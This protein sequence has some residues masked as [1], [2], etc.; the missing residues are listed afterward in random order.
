MKPPPLFRDRPRAVQVVLGLIAPV[1]FGALC[2]YLLGTSEPWFNGLMVL[3]GLGGIG[4]GYEHLGARDG[5]LRGIVGGVLFAAALLAWF[6]LRALPARV[7]LPLPVGGMAAVYALSGPVLGAL[8]GRL[9]R[10]SEDRQ[11]RGAAG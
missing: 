10:R 1:A 9:R 7:P 2:G 11:A 5:A 4:A 6:S 8:G 3:A